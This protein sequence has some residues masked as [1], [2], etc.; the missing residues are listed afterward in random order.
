[1]TPAYRINSSFPS[2]T[3]LRGSTGSPTQPGVYWFQNE[4]TSQALMVEVRV[5][6]GQLTVWWPIQDVPAT[7]L[8]GIWRGPIP[9]TFGPG[10]R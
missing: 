5:T 6:H 8:E 10:N 7:N 9:P 4:T 2:E 3:D 1:M